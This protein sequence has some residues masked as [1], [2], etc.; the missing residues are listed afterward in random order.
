MTDVW[1]TWEGRTVNGVFPLRLFLGNSDHSV[2]FLTSYAA[3]NIADA[4]IKL[5]PLEAATAD[6]QLTRWKS[7]AT[8]VH[9]H[10]VRIFESGRCQ[11]GGH[12][13]L[14]VVMEYAE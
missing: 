10:L 6:A 9:P 12:P 5:L 2:A 8:L 1:S 11:L 13:F 4:V 7:A 14:F 3:L